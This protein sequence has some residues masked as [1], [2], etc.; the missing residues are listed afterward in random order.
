MA[1]A[2]N[3]VLQS[4][5][6]ILYKNTEIDVFLLAEYDERILHFQQLN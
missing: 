3:L 4:E 5:N 1:S 6:R 2:Q